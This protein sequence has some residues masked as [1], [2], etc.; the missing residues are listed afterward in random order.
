MRG[1]EDLFGCLESYK[2]LHMGY[3]SPSSI[4]F[5]EVSSPSIEIAILIQLCTV[6]EWDE[7]EVFL[8]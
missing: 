1:V 4:L 6:V 2:R 8:F 5:W 3:I 7:I